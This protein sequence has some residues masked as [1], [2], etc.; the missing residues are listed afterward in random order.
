MVLVC[1]TEIFMLA[2]YCWTEMVYHIS[3]TLGCVRQASRS[4]RLLL[5]YALTLQ[6]R[7]FVMESIR[8]R[9]MYT[10]SGLL[11]GSC[12]HVD[13][14]LLIEIIFQSLC[15]AELKDQDRKFP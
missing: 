7:F 15:G 1:A 3:V 4:V 6:L 12:S 8:R 9:Q 10:V 13:N 14:H 11:Y 5:V 2:T